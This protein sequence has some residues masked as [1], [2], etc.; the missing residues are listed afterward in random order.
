MRQVTLIMYKYIYV[1]TDITEYQTTHILSITFIYMCMLVTGI[2]VR[3]VHLH[4]RY[5]YEHHLEFQDQ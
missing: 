1:R 2:V 3:G 5:F 4:R